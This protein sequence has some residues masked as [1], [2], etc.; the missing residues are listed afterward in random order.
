MRPLTPEELATYIA[1]EPSSHDH[2]LSNEGNGILTKYKPHVPISACCGL[3][4]LDGAAVRPIHFTVHEFLKRDE[5]GIGSDVEANALLAESMIHFMIAKRFGLSYQGG[6]SPSVC[7]F[8]YY[9]I[10]KLPLPLPKGLE[11]VLKKLGSDSNLRLMVYQDKCSRRQP[12]SELAFFA[13]FDL[14]LVYRNFHPSESPTNSS[15]EVQ[16]A[17]FRAAEGGSISAL[18]ELLDLLKKE[19][20]RDTLRKALYIASHGGQVVNGQ[21]KHSKC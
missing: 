6:Y 4:S 1:I 16:D 5:R 2:Y 15:S 7:R 12:I 13:V 10:Q 20:H 19:L 8:W 17:L 14:L 3:L 9:Y 11:V 18:V 21:V